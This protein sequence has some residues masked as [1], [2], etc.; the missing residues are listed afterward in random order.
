MGASTGTGADL[1]S[2]AELIVAARAGDA[3]AFGVLYERHAGAALV[4]ARQYS[5]GHAE[6]EDVVA[7]SFAAV[8]SALQKGSGPNDSFR[9]YLFTAVRRTAGVQRD[10]GR[11]AEPTDDVGVLEAGSLAEPGAEEPA[12]AGFERTVV[13]RA[14][15]SLPERWQAVLWHSEVEGLNPAQIAPLLGLSANSTAALAYRAREGLRQA[16]LQ[17]HLHDP[18]DDG[19]RSVAGKLG[20][21][22]RGGLGQRDNAHVEAH[23]DECGDCRALVL[24][25]RDVNHGLKGVIAPLVLGAA[26]MGA[27]GFALPTSGG[28]AAG[29]ASLT[30]GGVGAGAAGATA[31]AGG[32]AAAAA[33]VGAAGAVGSGIAASAL[34]VGSAAGGG[35]LATV[36]TALAAIPVAVVATVAGA[37]VVGGVV[38]G[39]SQLGGDGGDGLAASARTTSAEPGP[40]GGPTSAD[41]ASDGP[42]D[43]PTDDDSGAEPTPT[44]QPESNGATGGSGGA[45]GG[46][47]TGAGTGTGGDSTAPPAGPAQLEV[48]DPE[49]ALVAG[50]TG[51]LLAVPVSNT[52]GAAATNVYAVV[53]LPDGVELEPVAARVVGVLAVR[54]AAADWSCVVEDESVRC[55]LP[56]L[57]GG[58]KAVL[59]LTVSVDEEYEAS[60]IEVTWQLGADGLDPVSQARRVAVQPA[61]ARLMLLRTYQSLTFE[62]RTSTPVTLAIRNAGGVPATGATVLLDGPDGLLVTG[63]SAAWTCAPV[64]DDLGCT[65]V[66]PIPARSTL[67]LP[68]SVAVAWWAPN[69]T[70]DV[71]LT[72]GASDAVPYTV[73]PQSAPNLRHEVVGTPG[74]TTVDVTQIGA[75]LLGCSAKPSFRTCWEGSRNNNDYGK[76]MAPVRAAVEPDAALSVSSSS[77]LELPEGARVEWAGLYW[78]A[79]RAATDRWSGDTTTARLR[80]P[81]G[82]YLPVTGTRAPPVTD[83]AN[84][85]YYQSFADVTALVGGLSDPAGLWSVADVAISADRT[86]ADPT[87]YA[88][89]SLVVLYSYPDAEAPRSSAGVYDGPAWI[90]ANS[91][92]NLPI[93]AGK[94]AAVRIGVVAWE[95]DRNTSGDTLALDGKRLEPWRLYGYGSSDNAFDS[96]AYGFGHPN[97]LGVDAK[98]FTAVTAQADDVVLTAATRGDQFLLGVVTVRVAD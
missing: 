72:P 83:N 88:G 78:S 21:Y 35:F 2:D 80:A 51:Q 18:L 68:I 57:P 58:E 6:A 19:C 77:L 24:E 92:V 23:L 17:Q 71:R 86:D 91:A 50:S 62:R 66:A 12:L 30:A 87:Y 22:V 64:G 48:G 85:V 8:W 63:G 81:D 46:T 69:G 55:S 75:P 14:F 79:N 60:D 97:S 96:S 43:E 20:G 32:A 74:V 73:A 40:N 28:L 42:T 1:R 27:L 34:G 37:L 10:R 89:W 3:G 38:I 41:P 90:A 7:D 45:G 93:A 49:G 13:A 54:Q 47:G 36:G 44:S 9:A 26:G 84:R 31:G 53:G 25:L 15:A 52:G 5:S 16:Y 61:P 39:I 95:G 4:V 98:A 70:L 82:E 67:P 76:D 29:A 33:G 59:A 94:G 65:A 56:V 11:R